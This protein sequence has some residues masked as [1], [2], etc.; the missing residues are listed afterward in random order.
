[1]V[2]E[3]RCMS[4]KRRPSNCTCYEYEIQKFQK[5]HAVF[6]S[7]V[8]T[9]PV[10]GQE[11][12]TWQARRNSKERIRPTYVDL[13][14]PIL[15]IEGKENLAIVKAQIKEGE[16]YYEDFLDRDGFKVARFERTVVRKF[17]FLRPKRKRRV[18]V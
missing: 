6:V 17:A 14:G 8:C 4:C 13:F 1:M 15:F 5:G 10:R 2:Q 18:R 12:L 16:F 3:V 7:N 11:V 9:E